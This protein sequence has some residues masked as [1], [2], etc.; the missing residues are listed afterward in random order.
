[1]F[2]VMLVE[3]WNKRLNMKNESNEENAVNNWTVHFSC[4]KKLWIEK[5]CLSSSRI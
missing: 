3:N 4:V 2:W 1:M 5:L